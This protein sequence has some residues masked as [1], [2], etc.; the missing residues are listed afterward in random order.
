MTASHLN[1]GKARGALCPH[2]CLDFG[3]VFTTKRGNALTWLCSRSTSAGKELSQC[4]KKTHPD[5]GSSCQCWEHF[6]TLV[7]HPATKWRELLPAAE[8]GEPWWA[9][10]Y[11]ILVLWPAGDISWRLLHGAVSTGM[12]LVHF[13][14]VPEAC[15]F[16]GMRENLAHVFFKCTSLQPL[17]QL[18]LRFWMH[19][20]PHLFIYLVNLLLAMT[21]VSI[22]NTRERRLAEWGPCDYGAVFH[23]FICSRIQAEFLWAVSSGSLDTFEEQWVLCG[24]LCSVSPS[25]S[26][27]LAF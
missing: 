22:R 5:Q 27:V 7:S 8:G 26:L 6:P 4:C 20:S 23:S 17:F 1:E 25:G 14:F 11:S 9:S 2:P 21:K 13:T 12:S 16:C 3:D 10:L 15:S 18:L 24:V 19:F